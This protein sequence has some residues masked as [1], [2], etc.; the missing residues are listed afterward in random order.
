M[1]ATWTHIASATAQLSWRACSALAVGDA[2]GGPVETMTREAIYKR[3][4]R[5]VREMVGGGWLKLKPG[6]TT[7]DTAMARMLAES[8]VECDGV[9]TADIA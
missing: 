4:G 6:Q 8:I 5:P 9:D 7:D 2:L 3:H 1:D